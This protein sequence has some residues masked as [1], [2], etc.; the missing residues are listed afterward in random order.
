MRRATSA[1]DP[2]RV[3]EGINYGLGLRYDVTHSLGLRVEYARFGR[4]TGETLGGLPEADQV[5]IGVQFRF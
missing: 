5:S 4:F 2:H 1:G 3:H